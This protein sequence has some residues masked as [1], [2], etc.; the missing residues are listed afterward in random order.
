[1][2]QRSA[3]LL[4]AAAIRAVNAFLHGDCLH[5]W[6]LLSDVCVC[7]CLSYVWL[8]SVVWVCEWV[9]VVLDRSCIDY[10][11]LFYSLLCRYHTRLHSVQNSVARVVMSDFLYHSAGGILTEL[12]WFPVQSRMFFKLNCLIYTILYTRQPVYMPSL[13]HYY[14]LTILY[15]HL[16]KLWFLLSL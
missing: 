15:V 2:N 13:L 5:C 6:E 12:H 8:V 1:V 14:T 4:T 3:G 16:T 11:T 9:N 10:T 7:A